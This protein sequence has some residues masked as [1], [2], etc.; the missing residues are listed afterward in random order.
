MIQKMEGV[1]N[2]FNDAIGPPGIPFCTL[3]PNWR[4]SGGKEWAKAT[5]TAMLAPGAAPPS[6][7]RGPL[8]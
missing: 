6:I 5:L 7:W 8:F 2:F 3:K 4:R 1:V